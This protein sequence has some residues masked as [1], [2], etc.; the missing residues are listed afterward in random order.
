MK[1][2]RT[3][4]ARFDGLIDF[5]FE[6]HYLSIDDTEGGALRVHY[7]D[8]GPAAV[9]PVLLM[10]GEPT[11]S[12][13]YRHMIPILTQAG[14]RVVAPDL[15]GFGRSDKPAERQDYTYQRHVDWMS[16]VLDQ[17]DLH[18]ITLVCQDWGGLIGL[19]L[20]ARMPQRFIRVVVANT[21]LPTGDQPLGAAF[22]SWRAY[23]QGVA[24]FRAGRIV[25]GGSVRELSV[26]EMQAYD[27]PFP[28]ESYKAGA[29]Q[30]PMLVPCTAEDVETQANAEA[31]EVLRGLEVPVLTLFGAEDKI[32]AGIDQVFQ[33]QMPGAM[34]QSH[35]ILPEAG[36]FLQED[37]GLDL[38]L[39]I[40]AFMRDTAR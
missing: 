39:R 25:Q 37:V 13:L 23:S 11:W 9:A 31:W 35:Q 3:P 1:V 2:L 12:Y 16:D 8:E 30:F 36:H 32:M 18:S 26:P 4:D 6:P 20:L 40:N 10:H 5:P 17:L 7:L 28:D 19:R 21:A 22:E 33:S 15:V 14:H 24:E 34:G 29:R 38:A 27:A